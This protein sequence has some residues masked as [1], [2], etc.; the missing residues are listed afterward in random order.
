M[1]SIVRRTPLFV[2]ALLLTATA[3]DSGGDIPVIDHQGNPRLFFRDLVGDKQVVLSFVYTRCKGVCPVM[4]R[5][6][7]KLQTQLGKRLRREVVLISVSLDPENDTPEALKLW[8]E[9]AGARAG[10][11]LIT[12]KQENLDRVSREVLGDVIPREGHSPFMVVRGVG[13][14]WIRLSG[15]TDAREVIEALAHP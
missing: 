6:F 3:P 10:W 4:G 8:G 14:R 1:P 7:H 11:T 9:R 5:N 2:L 13:Q 15:L 12:G